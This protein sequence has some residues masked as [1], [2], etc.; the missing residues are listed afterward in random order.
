MRARDFIGEVRIDDHDGWGSV[1][2]N[3]NV[4]YLG[5]RVRMRPSMFLR[6]AAPLRGEGSSEDI[7]DHIRQGG[8]IGSP[9]LDISIPDG[10]FSGDFSRPARVMGH[11]GRNRM[12]AVRQVEGDDPIQ[13]HLFF[14]DGL[15]RRHL[16]DEIIQ[17]LNR[18]LAPQE[19][20]GAG[21]PGPYFS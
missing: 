2:N 8:A 3:L 4:D 11:E 21:F 6:L 10:W 18:R 9:F 13:V 20:P 5:L 1:P 14:R 12:M 19:Q 16:T 17:Q 15:R 7:A